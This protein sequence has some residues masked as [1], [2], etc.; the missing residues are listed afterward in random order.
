[1]AATSSSTATFASPPPLASA[2]TCP[3]TLAGGLAAV[4]KSVELLAL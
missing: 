3:T 4:T 2:S 1:L